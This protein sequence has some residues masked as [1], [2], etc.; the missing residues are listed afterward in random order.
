MQSGRRLIIERNNL[1]NL[2]G[3]EL[4]FDLCYKIPIF[5]S[6]Y[7]N[8]YKVRK[9]TIVRV[10]LTHLQKEELSS[11]DYFETDIVTVW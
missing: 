5:A 6:F 8:V 3:K 10:G 1:L 2:R 4:I 7:N 9:V 11:D